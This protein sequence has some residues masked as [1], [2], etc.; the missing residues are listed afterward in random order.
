MAEEQGKRRPRRRRKGKKPSDLPRAYVLIGMPGSGKSALGR[1]VARLLDWEFIDTDDVLAKMVGMTVGELS[2]TVSNEEFRRR[3]EEAVLSIG[4]GKKIIAT[5]GSVVYG[6]RA[7][8]HLKQ[9][10]TVIYLDLPLWMLIR[11]IGDTTEKR[12]VILKKGQSLGDLFHERKSLYKRYA[13]IEFQTFKLSPGKSSRLMA[14]LIRFME[15]DGSRTKDMVVTE[16]SR[17]VT[18]GRKS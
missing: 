6:K 8:Q 3:E 4:R 12:G 9:I 13:D 15:D 11:R 7:M 17:E 14:N 16:E 1:R 2:Q 18:N 10:G 5:G